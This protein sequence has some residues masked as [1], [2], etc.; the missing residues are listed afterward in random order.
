MGWNKN[1]QHIAPCK[2]CK[3]RKVTIDY[4]CHSKGNC[5]LYDKWLEEE[6][7]IERKRKEA[8]KGT[9]IPFNQT[10]GNIYGKRH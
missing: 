8:N 6:K 1:T 7:E 10:R 4:N 3:N 5:P 2:N 9:G